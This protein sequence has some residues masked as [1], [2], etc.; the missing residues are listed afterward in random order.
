MAEETPQ[1]FASKK[2]AA[3][4]CGILLGT[5]GIHK[6]V[7]GMKKP[8]LIML[9]VSILTCGIGAVPMS[10]IGLVEGIMYLTKSDEDFYQLYYVQKKEWF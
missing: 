1:S 7:L 5:L 6:F 4:I 9:L 10:I 2:V 3:G 8:G